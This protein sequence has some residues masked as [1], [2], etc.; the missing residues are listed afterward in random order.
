MAVSNTCGSQHHMPG[1]STWL[2]AL[3][4]FQPNIAVR[5][6]WLSE[7]RGALGQEASRVGQQPMVG[8]IT[9]LSASHSSQN[10]MVVSI[11]W[12]S[13]SSGKQQQIAGS[14]TWLSATH[15][16]E[17]YVVLMYS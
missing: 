15:S 12:L 3:H 2:T 13:A 9:W 14:I 4:G 10:H 11:T 6:T 16:W 17:Q 1:S 5:I 8:I 7:K